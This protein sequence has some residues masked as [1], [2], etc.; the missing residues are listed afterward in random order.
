MV[1]RAPLE[2]L[3]EL[4]AIPSHVSQPAGIAAIG[5]IVGGELRSLGLERVDPAPPVRR[6]PAWAEDVL[7]PEVGFDDLPDPAV[8]HRSGEL[9]GELL[10]L[11]DLD[12]ALAL[13]ADECRL[14]VEGGRAIGPAVADM[15]GGLVV[16]V[17]A[18]RR[19]SSR[20]W[21]SPSVTVVLSADEQAGSLRS[22]ETIRL[23][24]TSASWSVC[25]ECGRDGGRV[26][27]TR[28]HIGVG[29]LN[30]SGVEAHA[31]SA[32]EAGVNAIT[33]LARGIA[34][35]DAEGVST[36][37][38]TVTPTI[39]TGGRRRSL[40]PAAA[41]V[42]LDVR[43][44][45][46]AAWAAL[47]ARMR[48]ALGALDPPDRLDLQLFNHRPGIPWT[49]HGRG[50]F[51]VVRAVGDRIGLDVEAADSLAAGSTAFVDATRIPVLDGMGPAGGALMTT[52]EYIEVDSLES[53][54]E[55]LAGTIAALGKDA[56]GSA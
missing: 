39:V 51:S 3:A 45:D 34:T 26:M 17:E 18:L 47:D 7:S 25:L 40:V 1:E 13:D 41:S 22:A 12:A 28:G 46:A 33:A 8:W 4:V 6:A 49:E 16:M 31:G 32:R 20:G 44:R 36:P 42:V 19:V 11:A 50:L 30:A 5:E 9:P 10:I 48:G 35:L 56:S 21:A 55:L 52:R 38:A 2:L 24:A 23:R 15:K 27:R 53:R 14:V 29:R 43:A 37:D 54:A